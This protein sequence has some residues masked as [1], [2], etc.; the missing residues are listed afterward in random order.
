MLNLN[1]LSVIS[2]E[3]R[4]GAVRRALSAISNCGSALIDLYRNLCQIQVVSSSPW[5]P[6]SGTELW[7]LKSSSFWSQMK[8]KVSQEQQW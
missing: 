3:Q 7:L 4:D 8:E 1:P 6:W 2:Q 5:S